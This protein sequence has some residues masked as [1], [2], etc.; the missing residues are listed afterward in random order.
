M[1]G[2]F[3]GRFVAKRE[4]NRGS[5]VAAPLANKCLKMDQCRELLA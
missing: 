1:T 2:I 4:N 3:Q 5:W